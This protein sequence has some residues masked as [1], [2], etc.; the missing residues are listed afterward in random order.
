[1]I[2]LIDDQLLGAVLRGSPSPRRHAAIYT[3]G[4]FYVRLCRAVLG[5]STATGVLSAPFASLTGE[6]RARA[7]RSLLELPDEI[8]LVSLRELAP[9][10]GQLRVRHDLNVLG[11]EVLAAAVSLEADVYL[12]APSPRLENSLLGEGRSV[13][14]L[15]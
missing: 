1:M 10:I 15:A 9:V 4:Y 5:S 2:D 12:S 14:I 7:M 13:Q 11:M 3:T 6:L 8:G